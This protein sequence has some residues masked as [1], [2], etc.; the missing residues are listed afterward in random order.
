MRFSYQCVIVFVVVATLASSISA[1]TLHHVRKCPVLCSDFDGCAKCGGI[2]V[3]FCDLCPG[4]N[5][6]TH[7]YAR[8]LFFAR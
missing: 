1:A 6:T 3:S 7:R 4:F 5:H 8:S 2:C